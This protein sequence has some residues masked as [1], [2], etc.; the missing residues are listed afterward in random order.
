MP[1]ANVAHN[2][3][4]VAHKRVDI[5]RVWYSLQSFLI[6]FANISKIFWTKKQRS[7][8]ER[9]QFLRKLLDVDDSSPFKI[10]DPR[11]HF[12]H[13]D[14]RIDDWY[15]SN[16]DH[17]FADANIGPHNFVSADMIKNLIYGDVFS[18]IDYHRGF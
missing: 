9:G 8:E 1:V 13:F 14:E 7:Y 12:E 4:L 16:P 5:D 17:N 11:N 3:V 2:D 18:R 10:R 15:L 6:A